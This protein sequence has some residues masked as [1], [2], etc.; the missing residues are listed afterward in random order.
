MKPGLMGHA[1]HESRFV[2]Q[3]GHAWEVFADVQAGD[4]GL[5]RLELSA[6]LRR[7]VL[8]MMRLSAVGIEPK[9]DAVVVFG[10]FAR[11]TTQLEGDI[12]VAIIVAADLVENPEWLASVARWTDAVAGFAGNPVSE[13]V[14]TVD[15]LCDRVETPL[16]Q[17]INREGIVLTGAT[18]D[19]VVRRATAVR[20]AGE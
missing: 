15:E 19:E 16:W 5:D 18:V 14:V 8:E 1:A 9:P 3:P 12:D 10:S 7:T 17:G 11:G 20:A 4:A 6:N 13:L 2:H